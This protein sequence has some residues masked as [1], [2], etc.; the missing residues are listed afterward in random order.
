MKNIIF[1]LGLLTFL[2]G[3]GFFYFN[4]RIYFPQKKANQ[5]LEQGKLFFEQSDNDSL[6][7]AIHQF[8]TTI[9]HFPKTKEAKEA[10]FFL[11][12]SYQ[13]LGMNDIAISKYN[14]LLDSKTSQKLKTQA[15]Q[16]I[17]YLEEL[18]RYQK[19]GLSGLTKMLRNSHDHIVRSEIYLEM[20]RQLSRSGKLQKALKHYALSL[21]ENSNNIAAWSEWKKLKEIFEQENSFSSFR[22]KGSQNPQKEIVSSKPASPQEEMQPKKKKLVPPKVPV[23]KEVESPASKEKSNTKDLVIESLLK[24]ILSTLDF[25]KKEKELPPAQEK[26]EKKAQ[27]KSPVKTEANK[28]SLNF[29]AQEYVLKG[30]DLYNQNLDMQ[31]ENYFDFVIEKYP[32]TAAADD[33]LYY[34]GN[35]AFRNQDLTKAI[36]F[37]NAALSNQNKKRDEI[38]YIRKGEAYYHRGDYFR[39][40]HVFETVQRLYPNGRYNYIARDWYKEVKD[41]YFHE[42]Q[43]NIQQPSFTNENNAKAPKIEQPNEIAIEETGTV[44]VPK[45]EVMPTENSIDDQTKPALNDIDNEEPY[46]TL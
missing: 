15:R 44:D 2:F 34:S 20:A 29:E 38:S 19:D 25:L 8:A 14:D 24:K 7:K 30:I 9:S 33:A 37:F 42:N 27:E 10:M 41:A 4:E 23:A 39:A 13:K 45:Q 28:H 5:F 40:A 26:V 12:Q 11:A 22:K 17:K 3:A 21:K 6:Q 1:R 31:A 36:Y 35:I 43:K 32:D 16:K 18:D 46:P